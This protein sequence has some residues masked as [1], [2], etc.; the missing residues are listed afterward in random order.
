MDEQKK[1]PQNQ[2]QNPGSVVREIERPVS[3]YA[4]EK[5]PQ[6]SEELKSIGIESS[7]ENPKVDKANEQIGV[8][9]SLESTPVPTQ[10]NSNLVIPKQIKELESETKDYNDTDSGKAQ[11]K[12]RIR[13]LEREL[14]ELGKAA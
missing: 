1:L 2:P 4:T 7:S 9:V 14:S 11:I 8:K 13:Q 12:V 6:I 3:D 5:T 10:P